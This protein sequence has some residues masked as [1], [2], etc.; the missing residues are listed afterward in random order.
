MYEVI[1]AAINDGGYKLE[2]MLSRIRTFAAKG[3]ISAEEMAELEEYAREHATVR[4]DTDLFDK[5][6]ELEMRVRALEETGGGSAAE[7]PKYTPGKWY[8]NGDTCS[9]NGGNYICIAPDSVVCTWSP[10]EYPAYWKKVN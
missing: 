2:N 8:R 4:N 3:L 9:E 10:S 7:Y 5:V 1:K 6:M